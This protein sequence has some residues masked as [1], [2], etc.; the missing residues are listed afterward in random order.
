MPDEMLQPYRIEG[1]VLQLGEGASV[2]F[3]YPIKAVISFGEVLVVLVLAPIGG[4]IYNQNVFGVSRQGHI[5][6]QVPGFD[7][8]KGDSPYMDIH[9]DKDG[10][11]VWL[12]NYRCSNIFLDPLSGRFIREEFSH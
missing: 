11:L 1:N 2:S 3:E 12:G 6:W 7:W 8:Q 5:L 9:K 4:P 10:K